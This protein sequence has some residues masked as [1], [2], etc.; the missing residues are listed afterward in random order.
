MYLQKFGFYFF[1]SL[2][3]TRIH[4]HIQNIS[5]KTAVQGIC[6]IERDLQF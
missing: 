2:H 6:E 5:K 3:Y 4:E 1:L